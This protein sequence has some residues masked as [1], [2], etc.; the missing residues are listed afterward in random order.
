MDR[1]VREVN[2]GKDMFH[3]MVNRGKKEKTE[4]TLRV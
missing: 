4:E 2:H 1:E 3:R